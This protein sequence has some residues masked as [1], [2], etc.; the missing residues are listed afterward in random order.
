MATVTV[1]SAFPS[2]C[3]GDAVALVFE[4]M[5]ATRPRPGGPCQL[6][7]VSFPL[8]SSVNVAACKMSTARRES[9]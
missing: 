1:T 5:A 2:S 9:S 4:Y 7:S 8:C 3:G 6:A